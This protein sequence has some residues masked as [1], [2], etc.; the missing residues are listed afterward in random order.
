M[1]AAFATE[2]DVSAGTSDGGTAVKHEPVPEWND[3]SIDSI[4][5]CD[6]VWEELDAIPGT[7]M[8]QEDK[9]AAGFDVDEF[10]ATGRSCGWVDDCPYLVEAM[11]FVEH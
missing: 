2:A 9:A 7:E 10:T 4:C 3:L 1:E 5:D 11:Q 8:D 6:D